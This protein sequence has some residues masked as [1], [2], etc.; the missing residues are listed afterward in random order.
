LY[1]NLK[2][3]FFYLYLL[4]DENEL[5][6]WLYNNIILEN[7]RKKD[8]LKKYNNFL[9]K[10]EYLFNNSRKVNTTQSL[11]FLDELTH[12]IWYSWKFIVNK[13]INYNSRNIN[14]MLDNLKQKIFI[15]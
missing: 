4:Y 12:E 7:Y 3:R 2:K 6:I 10:R 9:E 8:I 14:F 11:L 13:E 5:Q 1:K 15:L